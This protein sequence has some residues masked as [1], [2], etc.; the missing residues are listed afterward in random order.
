MIVTLWEIAEDA[1]DIGCTFSDS[2][3]CGRC[4][5]C[6]HAKTHSPSGKLV[7]D[8][9]DMLLSGEYQKLLSDTAE[10]EREEK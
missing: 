1:T 2:S 5:A 8:G 7:Q 4:P 3:P 10:P 6:L 9:R